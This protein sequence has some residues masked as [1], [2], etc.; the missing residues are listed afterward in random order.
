MQVLR[1]CWPGILQGKPQNLMA[2]IASL[3]CSTAT[4]NN[5]FNNSTSQITL[6][7]NLASFHS[8]FDFEGFFVFSNTCRYKLRIFTSSSTRVKLEL[9]LLR[10]QEVS[11]AV[12]WM[13]QPQEAS[14]PPLPTLPLQKKEKRKK[15][16]GSDGERRV[17]WLVLSGIK[18]AGVG[19]VGRGE[20]ACRLPPP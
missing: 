12:L 9:T 1:L 10:H 17:V 8:L 2:G 19:R 5:I 13:L 18:V 4:D 15:E 16:K 20:R 6:F 3:V 11:C 7:K 14:S